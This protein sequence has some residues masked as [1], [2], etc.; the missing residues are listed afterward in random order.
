MKRSDRPTEALD[1]E[2]GATATEYSVLAGFIAFVIL[3]GI[4]LF[5]TALNDYFNQLVDGL[6]AALGLP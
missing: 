3:A 6:K 5:G 4:G 2:K 1:P